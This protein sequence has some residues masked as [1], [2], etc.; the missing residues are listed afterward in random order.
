MY[1]LTDGVFYHNHELDA[2]VITP[3]IREAI[4]Q[5]DINNVK[6][7]DARKIINSKFNTDISYAQMAYELSKIKQN[8][9]SSSNS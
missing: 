8:S 9:Q 3:E 1:S 7:A 6:P 5:I 2:K 4:K